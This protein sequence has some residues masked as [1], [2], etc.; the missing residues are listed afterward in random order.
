[1]KQS[2]A[3][4][5]HLALS[6][7]EVALGIGIPYIILGPPFL[8]VLFDK[9]TPLVAQFIFMISFVVVYTIIR[10]CFLRVKARLKK[11]MES[12]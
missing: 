9:L 4:T 12:S 3:K 11:S 10:I 1:M 2:I 7:F 5:L 6:L 8:N